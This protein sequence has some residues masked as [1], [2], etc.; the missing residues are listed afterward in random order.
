MAIPLSK[1]DLLDI[2]VA[3]STLD[4]RLDKGFLPDVAKANEEIVNARFDAWCQ[5]VARGDLEQFRRRLAW[6]G[7]SEEMVRRILGAVSMPQDAPL[8]AWAV[9][10]GEVLRLAAG[11]S[12]NEATARQTGEGHLPFLKAK[13]PFPFEE[14]L[15]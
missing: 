6:D 8:P 2:V 13:E 7:R 11:L 14:I 4:E 12:A 10:L 5:T 3:A 15:V 9:T 1:Q